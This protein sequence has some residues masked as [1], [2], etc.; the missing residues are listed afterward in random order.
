MMMQA[1][2]LA[3]LCDFVPDVT[4]INNKQF[5]QFTVANNEGSLSDRY[6]YILRMSQV[7]ETVLPDDVKQKIAKFRGLLQTTTT[8]KDLVTDEEKEITG[9]SPMVI[10]YNDRMANYINTA[11]EYNQHRIDALAG[12]DPKDVQYWAINAN[13]LRAKVRAAMDDWIANGY[14]DD[15]EEIGAFIDQVQ[16]R[17]MSML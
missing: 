9:P 16:A 17:D 4:T 5:S 10:A 13:L 8:K 12:N 14:K 15:Y 1:E 11:L 6:E 3:R 7:M 2:Q